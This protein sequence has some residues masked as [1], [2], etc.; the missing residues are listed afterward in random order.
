MGKTHL[1]FVGISPDGCSNFDGKYHQQEA[2][3]LEGR[4]GVGEEQCQPGDQENQRALGEQGTV[5]TLWRRG[6]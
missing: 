1:I 6:I 3:E 5:T 2:E 4:E